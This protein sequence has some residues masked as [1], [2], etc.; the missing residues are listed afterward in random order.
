MSDDQPE[1]RRLT[2]GELVRKIRP[3]VY[4]RAKQKRKTDK[5]EEKQR[6]WE[7][8]GPAEMR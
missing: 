7:P 2:Y 6:I 4:R 1:L 5:V 8:G 3:D